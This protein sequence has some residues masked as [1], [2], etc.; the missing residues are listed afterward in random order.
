[1]ITTELGIEHAIE[2]LGSSRR[3]GKWDVRLEDLGESDIRRILFQIACGL[4][5]VD[6]EVTDCDGNP[7]SVSSWDFKGLNS[8][9]YAILFD[10]RLEYLNMGIHG[11]AEFEQRDHGA[12]H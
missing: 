12:G 8:E 5:S 7:S 10:S 11:V 4:P 9:E 2:E 1:M 3:D 6:L